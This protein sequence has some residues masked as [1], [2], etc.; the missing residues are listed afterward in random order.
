ME[1]QHQGKTRRAKAIADIGGILYQNAIE[2]DM[3]AIRFYLKTHAGWSEK[4]SLELKSTHEE[5]RT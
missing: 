1:I 2:G 5:D 3:R 4:G